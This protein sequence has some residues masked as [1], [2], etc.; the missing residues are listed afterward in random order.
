MIGT[1]TQAYTMLEWNGETLHAYDIGLED[2][3]KENIAQS[4]SVSLNKSDSAPTASFSITPNPA[5]FELFQKL[6]ANALD[7][8]FTI[9]Y[10]YLNS[11]S[12]MGPMK[13]RFSGVQLTT[14]H[15]PKLE[16]S[17]TSV[18]K[19]AWTD[20]KISYTMEK[21]VPLTNYPEFV[22]EKC[23]TGCRDLSFKFVG[24]AKEKAASIMVKGNQMQRTPQN[25][26]V[27]VLRP[28]GMELQV[29]DNAFNGEII[30]S[31]DP[32]KA[33][34]LQKDK[35]EVNKAGLKP[36]P[37]KR[38]V[39]IIG[40][41]LMENITRK[42]SFNTG[43]SATQN[44]A[45]ADSPNTPQTNQKAV[46][47]PQNAAPQKDTAASSN[48]AGGTSGQ[49]DP[50]SSNT[51]SSP[52]GA[53]GKEASAALAKMLTTT[54]N[55]TVLMV[56]YMVGIKPRDL[57]AIPS[58][59][60]PGS[61]IEDWEVQSVNYKQDDVG[62]V[63]ISINGKRPYTGEDPLLDADTLSEVKSVVS[64]LKTPAAWNKFYWNQGPEVDRPLSS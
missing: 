63:S 41:G 64:N 9:T 1:L 60:G 10:G 27:D 57:I 30:I 14:G 40:P 25:I 15:D 29:G 44:A 22:K 47:E 56:P 16:I 35:P 12:T 11:N 49:S 26:L 17:G 51:G 18:I 23:G 48:T 20:N 3:T 36:E 33:G 28:H 43:S 53:D 4:V 61:Y 59:K 7:K 34:E 32:A 58:L 13:F 37:G 19:G 39:F 31:Y 24:E 21:E 2:G 38:K 55:F 46:A 5:G 45:S 6:K 8:P 62:G 54:C 52:A 42:Q 50:G